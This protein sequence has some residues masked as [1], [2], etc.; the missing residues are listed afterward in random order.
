MMSPRCEKKNS[1]MG[2]RSSK[3]LVQ[4]MNFSKI[5]EKDIGRSNPWVGTGKKRP[6]SQCKDPTNVPIMQ[7]ATREKRTRK[8]TVH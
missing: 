5:N 1:R 2:K 4:W 3:G 7:V 8:G 6:R